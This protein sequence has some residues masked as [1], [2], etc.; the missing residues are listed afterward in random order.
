MT[1]QRD[2]SPQALG[3]LVNELIN[4]R[5]KGISKNQQALSAWL[6]VNG[7]RERVHTVAVFLN[8]KNN[9]KAPSLVVYV[10]SNACVVDFN[11]S[12]E[13]YLA[14]LEGAGFNFSSIDF[15]LSRYAKEHLNRR[16]QKGRNTEKELPELTDEEREHIEK[17]VEG[18]P[19]NLKESVS[20]AISSSMRRQA[21]ES[22][23]KS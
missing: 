23:Q 21:A 18:L 19:Q 5:F 16:L 12:R 7:E 1:E 4:D 2:T 15:K 9:K 8:E 10:D 6:T 13:L 22:T 14:R 17:L 11:A 20:K 3:Q